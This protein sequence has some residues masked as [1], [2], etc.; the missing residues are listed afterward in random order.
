MPS[1]LTPL[2]G[3]SRL[4]GIAP[5]LCQPGMCSGRV[6]NRRRNRRARTFRLSGS[7]CRS[8]SAPPHL[9][10]PDGS[11]RL[12]VDDH[13]VIGVDQIIGGVPTMLFFRSA[14]SRP[15]R[16]RLRLY[17]EREGWTKL[18]PL[19]LSQTR[20]AT[21]NQSARFVRYLLISADAEASEAGRR[22]ACWRNLLFHFGSWNRSP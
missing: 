6:R 16:P 22:C 8:S 3:A 1:A 10:P 12:D 20:N 14:P 5:V 11:G 17:E 13:A 21:Q 18:W 2:L 7:I 9:R 15:F 19:T 4:G